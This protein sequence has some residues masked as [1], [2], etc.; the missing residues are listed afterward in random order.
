VPY[1]N[2]GKIIES[3]TSKRKQ[4]IIAFLSG[5]NLT[6]SPDQ[7]T[8]D[9]YYVGKVISS[10]EFEQ[11]NLASQTQPFIDY[12]FRLLSKGR[13]T[14]YQIREKL[15]HRKA[16]KPQVDEVIT[17]LKQAHLIDDQTLMKDWVHHFQQRGYGERV[18]REK[19]FEKKFSGELIQ[20]LILDQSIQ[21]EKINQLTIQLNQKYSRLSQRLKLETMKRR[22]LERGYELKLIT[23]C[24]LKLPQ[25]D[26]ATELV[27]LAEDIKKGK[28]LYEKRFAGAH[29]QEKLINF[30]LRK[31]YNYSIIKRLLKESYHGD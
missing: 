18:I 29:L 7:F 30:L 5:E 8:Q 14:E 13:Y 15:Y 1:G 21:D 23:A 28:R 4:I 3:I 25:D 2:T 9:Y 10:K 20:T 26:S 6:L 17:R 22:L 27:N 31:G 12:G 24:L 19:L 16:I 11:I